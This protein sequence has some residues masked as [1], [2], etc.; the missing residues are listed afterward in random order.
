MAAPRA[1]RGVAAVVLLGI[2]PALLCAIPAAALTS[3]PNDPFFPDQWALQGQPASIRA[4]LA[5]C[6]TT[7]AGITVADV[8]TGASFSHPDLAGKLVAGAQ[9]L[10]GTPY[11]NGAPTGGPGDPTAVSDGNGH[12]TM[13]AGIIA[14][15][16]DNARGIAAV[17]P[18]ARLLVVKVLGDDGRGHDTD[19]ANG[20]RWATDHG[21]QVINLSIGPEVGVSTGLT[22]AIPDAVHYAASKGVAVAIS[23]G[24]SA[25]PV[26]NY[27][28]LTQDALIVGALA[29][30]GTVATYSNAGVA[31][32]IYAPGGTG[33]TA[34]DQTTQLSQNIVSTTIPRNGNPDAYATSAGTSF[35]APQVAGTL[36][37]L[38]AQG[39]PAAQARQ[40]VLATAVR[41]NG[42][43]ELD[44]AAAVG[45]ERPCAGTPPPPSAALPPVAAGP[46]HSTVPV[47]PARPSTP[48]PPSPSATPSVPAT[49]ALPAIGATPDVPPHGSG[50]P[51][52]AGHGGWPIWLV[53]GLLAVLLAGAGWGLVLARARRHPD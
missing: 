35:A 30:D 25:L 40:R 22:S 46:S 49:P 45:A 1:R 43:A 7:G 42:V 11:P 29:P 44:A 27:P 51:S 48:P 13:T 14:A 38:M 17:A 32:S 10:G 21:A 26:S 2:V 39:L 9:Y 5:W 24:N 36:A 34:P 12:G 3:S 33:T 16:T 4:P 8:D 41:R 18:G 6:V 47:P 19:V 31:V 50:P 52:R 53:T 20:I 15:D 23:A 37:L 28:S